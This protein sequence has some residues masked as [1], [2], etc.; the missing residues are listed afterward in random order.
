LRALW[1]G[2]D[3]E[4]RA[5]EGDEVLVD[6]ASS[7]ADEVIEGQRKYAADG[8]VAVEA[9]AVAV[10]SEHEEEIKGELVSGEPFE[11]A[12]AQEAVRNEREA[13]AIDT[14]ESVWDDG[15]SEGT[16]P[17]VDLSAIRSC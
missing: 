6:E 3:L 15:S 11:E 8:V 17:L 16:E 1:Q 13:L 10:S 7:G 12:V 2:E 4:T 5:V 9:D 14:A